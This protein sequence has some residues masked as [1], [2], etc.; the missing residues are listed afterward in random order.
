M[1][2]IKYTASVLIILILIMSCSTSK[3]TLAVNNDKGLEAEYNY[4]LTETY[5]KLIELNGKPLSTVEKQREAFMILKKDTNK[6]HGNSSCNTFNGTY[7]VTNDTQISFSKMTSTMMA[8]INMVVENEF[9]N[10]VK[11]VD[12]FAIKGN[13]LSLSRARMAPL[14]K[15]EAVVMK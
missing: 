14:A 12:N 8:C 7:T 11:Q 3:N 2:K 15:F 13:I 4:S 6:V 9:L 5:W 1:K 10:V